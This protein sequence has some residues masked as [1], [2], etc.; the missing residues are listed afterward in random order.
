MKAISELIECAK[1]EV[2]MRERVYH[3]RVEAGKFDLVK[4]AHEL[5]CMKD[6]L[7][8]LET[9]EQKELSL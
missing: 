1:R 6:I 8:T 9:M 5:E 2:A 3:K 4:A 7:K